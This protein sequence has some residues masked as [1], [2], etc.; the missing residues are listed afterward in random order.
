MEA[1]LS[2]YVET[3]RVRGRVDV[4][5]D[6]VLA[7]FAI[8]PTPIVLEHFLGRSI[9]P[10]DLDAY[11][12]A[13]EAA[14]SGLQPFPGV[15]HMLERLERAGYRLGLFTSATRRAV[16]L[17]LP[18]IGLDGHFAATVTGDEVAHP[19]PAPDGL[20]LVCCRLGVST[21]DAVY[22]GDA[23]VDLVCAKSANVLGVQAVWGSAATL[24]DG[25]HLV[26][27]RPDDV[28]AFIEATNKIREHCIDSRGPV[29][30]MGLDNLPT[31][32]LS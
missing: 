16:R 11:Y 26:A 1:I 13:Y 22:V 17:V 32:L 8:G 4:T 24:H 19:K 29:E 27:K 21:R 6:D 25:D 23:A 9:S 7:Q 2:V 14:L 20:E 31:S 18:R 28:I 15:V 30:R 12:V 3:I 10:Q 5:S